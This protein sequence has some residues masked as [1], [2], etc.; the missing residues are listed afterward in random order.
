MMES[1]DR[2]GDEKFWQRN[3]EPG[4]PAE[5]D[6][7]S[8]IPLH[9]YLENTA[10]R[11]P[12]AT[13]L[14][15]FGVSMDYAELDRET[16]KF[17]QGL[18][19]EFALQPGDRVAVMLPNVMQFPVA[20]FGILRAGMVCVNINP[21][22]TPREL[23]HQLQDAGVKAIVVLENFAAVLEQ[24]IDDTDVEHVIVASVGDYLPGLK[25][26]M[27]NF[28]LRR[29]KKMVPSWNLPRAIRFNEFMDK[30]D[31]S[32]W[33]DHPVT[34]DD[35]A[36]LQYTGGTTGLSK[37]AIL[38][39]RNVSAN[40]QQGLAWCTDRFE[41]GREVAIT[42][43]PLYHIFALTANLMFM[44]AVGG[45]CVLITNPR[46]FRGFVRELGKW[47]MSYI[48]G[49]N[50]LYAALM[51]TP[52]IERV[53]FSGLKI[54]LGAGMAVTRPVAERWAA[55]TGKPLLEVYG[56]SETSPAVCMNR[57][58]LAEYN[59]FIGLPIPSTEVR[60]AD[61][62]GDALAIGEEGELCVRG[63]QVM[64][65]YWSN[66]A[67]TREVFTEDGF[68]RTGDIASMNTDGFVKIMDRKKDM[69]IVSGFNVYPNEIEDTV[70]AHA[71]VLEVAAVGVRD[72]R[73]GER[74]H[75]YV[76]KK[77]PQLTEEL[78]VTWCREQLTS[79]K[80]PNGVTF[81]DELPKSNVG[82]ILRRA[83]RDSAE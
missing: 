25:G 72:E 26:A 57:L 52:G 7:D 36:L 12:D 47:R 50:T 77:N 27:I 14:S 49:V 75:L 2:Q 83:L 41:P 39:H 73:S 62:R 51:N 60:I 71:D 23:R 46:D 81:L 17:A 59:G 55:L 53:D 56:L 68:F 21:L 65:G 22:Y 11:Y 1:A 29:V 33:A 15:N 6:A 8:L 31:G 63:P 20:L 3:Y 69:I 32:Q 42:A 61:G 28:V 48:T 18:C 40:I 78:L 54:A 66:E 9:R 38:T 19:R 13:A 58:D 76:V 79:Y 30:Q 37:G 10:R 67:A 64:R 35:I 45:N 82:K 74:V 5:I 24:V 16:R 4:V 43:L 80:V 70:G 44:T 34:I